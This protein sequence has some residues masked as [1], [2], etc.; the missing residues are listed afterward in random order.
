MHTC[1]ALQFGDI[2]M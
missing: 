2:I 1:V